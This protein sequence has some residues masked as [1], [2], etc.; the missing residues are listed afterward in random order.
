[1]S[2]IFWLFSKTNGLDLYLNAL[3]LNASILSIFEQCLAQCYSSLHWTC[4][5]CLTQAEVPLHHPSACQTGAA[6]PCS[7]PATAVGDTLQKLLQCFFIVISYQTKKRSET[8]SC[9][10][11]SEESLLSAK[12]ISSVGDSKLLPSLDWETA[13]QLTAEH[14]HKIDWTRDACC[15]HCLTWWNEHLS[16]R[17]RGQKV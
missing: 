3:Y 17:E 5:G 12:L 8:G 14:A 2:T 6:A 9:F 4:V 11:A 13:S 16:D 10:Q 1:M 7:T 15:Y